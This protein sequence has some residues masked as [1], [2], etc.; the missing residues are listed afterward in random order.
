MGQAVQLVRTRPAS[1]R[2]PERLGQSVAAQGA[3]ALAPAR[4]RHGIAA[5]D[6]RS[7]CAAG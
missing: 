4:V 6:W 7:G 5:W 1:G 2:R 3:R